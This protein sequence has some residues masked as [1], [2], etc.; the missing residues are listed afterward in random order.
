MPDNAAASCADGCPDGQF[1]GPCGEPGEK[2]I[3]NVRARDEKHE[4]YSSQQDE[5]PGPVVANDEV[6]EHLRRGATF[7][8]ELRMIDREIV[9][10]SSELFLHLR[11]RHVR[12]TTAV[13]LQIVL[14]VHRQAFRRKRDWNEYLGCAG[15]C[16]E[17]WRQYA[18]D[19][20]GQAVHANLT[21]DHL[22]I[23]AEPSLPQPGRQNC[24][25]FTT[26]PILRF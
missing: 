17:C 14:V 1:A 18:D 7:L 24:H 11:Q 25:L 8:V 19:L 6:A 2:Q 5:Q 3:G 15:E 22:G 12:A 23:A 21:A 13:Q 9:N 16:F 20:I 10:D 26:R 4:C